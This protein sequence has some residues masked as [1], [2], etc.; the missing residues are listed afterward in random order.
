MALRAADRD[1]DAVNM[2]SNFRYT[3]TASSKE[4]R[5]GIRRA[6]Q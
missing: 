6:G 2:S 3:S 1:E 4:R 5:P